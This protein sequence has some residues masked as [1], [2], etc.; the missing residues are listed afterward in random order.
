MPAHTTTPVTTLPSA[1]TPGTARTIARMLAGH[2]CDAHD[3]SIVCSFLA[4]FEPATPLRLA[5][6]CGSSGCGI[7][8]ARHAAW[9]LGRVGVDSPG[10]TDAKQLVA[11][12]ARCY[13]AVDRRGAWVD[14]TELSRAAATA[15]GDEDYQAWRRACCDAFD[16][17][18]RR[19][20]GQDARAAAWSGVASRVA[21]LHLL[22]ATVAEAGDL[23]SVV[24]GWVPADARA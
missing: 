6:S 12:W 22:G 7:G 13:E 1:R 3:A 20:I 21:V 24:R 2:T 14:I 15:A 17:V 16:L 18:T 19:G 8:V 11:T 9:M 10:T 4:S 5:V 23:E